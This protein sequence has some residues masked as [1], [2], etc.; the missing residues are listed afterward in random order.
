MLFIQQVWAEC[1]AMAGFVLRVLLHSVV[2]ETEK[3]LTGTAAWGVGRD[4]ALGKGESAFLLPPSG[5]RSQLWV[6]WGW[7]V[8]F[9]YNRYPNP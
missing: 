2:N 1:P 9:L 8:L 5:K 6:G 3:N 4:G 7:R